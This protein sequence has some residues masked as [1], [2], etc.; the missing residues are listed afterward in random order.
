MNRV[1]E[2]I[3]AWQSGDKVQGFALVTKKEVRE[4]RRGQAF[5]DLELADRS[6][7][8]AA[9]V[10]ADSDALEAEFAAH[11]FVKIRG[12]VQ[13]YRERL[14]LVI[15]RCRRA[16][17]ED[18]ADGFDEKLLIPSTREDIDD[19][20]R[21]LAA[22]LDAVVRPELRRLAAETLAVYGERLRVH[23]AAKGM[24]HAYLGGLLEHVVSMAELA[25]KVCE[26]YRSLDRDLLL[27][28]VLFHDLGKLDELGAMPANEYTLEGRLVGHVVIGRDLLRERCAAVPGFP[29]ELRLQLE[30]MVLAHQGK[31][32]YAS[33]VEPATPE[34]LVLHYI[35]D[36]D[37][38]LNHFLHEPATGFT[39]HRGLGRHTWRPE[40]AAESEA[41]AAP[42][43]PAEAEPPA[44]TEPPAGLGVTAPAPE[45]PAIAEP[46]PARPAAPEAAAPAGAA[47]AAPPPEPVR[48]T[49]FDP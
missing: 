24:H 15:E 22:A 31:K 40:P 3:S 23:P 11:D 1:N 7:S 42:E 26:H 5:I 27:V 6:G 2:P 29:A 17:D 38:K 9:K 30:H 48:P 39:W 14:Q 47:P 4:D 32:E 28:G 44:E 43:P 21:R 49:L 12:R 46:E 33:P 16:G 25:L 13:E 18:R 45:E 36:L 20:E 37:S 41:P 34:A 35:D 10:W 19:L 8:L